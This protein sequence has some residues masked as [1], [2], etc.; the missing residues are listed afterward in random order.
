MRNLCLIS[1]KGT[2]DDNEIV[3]FFWGRFYR[4]ILALH[5]YR[6]LHKGVVSRKRE[7]RDMI[8]LVMDI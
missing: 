5:I 7:C 3:S 6:E 4:E 1:K 8:R 2:Y